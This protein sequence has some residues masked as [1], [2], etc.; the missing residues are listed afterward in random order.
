METFL[1]II[2][3]Y[4]WSHLM[5]SSN[6]M[7]LSPVARTYKSPFTLPV[8][9]HPTLG[10]LTP[11]IQGG[12]DRAIVL[13]SWGLTKQ[14]TPTKQYGDNFTFT[15][16]KRC[17]WVLEGLITWV[18]IAV[19]S[20]GVLLP[21]FRWIARK[22]VTQPGFGPAQET[23]DVKKKGA[24]EWMSV[25]TSADVDAKGEKKVLCNMRFEK[26]DAYALTALLIVEAG[27]AIL[28]LEKGEGDPECLAKVI[29]GGVLTPAC[30][31]EGYV[32]RLNEVGVTIKTRDL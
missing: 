23:F 28:D 22:V 17:K 18:T 9:R 25:G 1:S 24:L 6:P 27:L 16:F 4:P 14:Y 19:L 12:P 30:L 32:K 10:I 2:E 11:W 7:A 29:G 3:A 8:F 26:G 31:G 21:P 13:R 5:R 15:E 20:I